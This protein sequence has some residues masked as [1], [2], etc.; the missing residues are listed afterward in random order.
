MLLKILMALNEPFVT[1][2]PENF[3]GM[4]WNNTH[5]LSFFTRHHLESDKLQPSR[6]CNMR[7]ARV[8]NKL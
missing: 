2:L 4:Q 5:L 7:T 1:S 8:W 6:G 3:Q